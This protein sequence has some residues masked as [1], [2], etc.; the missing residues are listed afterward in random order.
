MKAPSR[1]PNPALYKDTRKGGMVPTWVSFPDNM[2]DD[3]LGCLSVSV[4]SINAS[5][6]IIWQ[7]EG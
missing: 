2:V 4:S 3:M 6:C 7:G 5:V 1:R